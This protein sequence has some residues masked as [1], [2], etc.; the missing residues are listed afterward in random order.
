MA[1]DIS[2]S[3]LKLTLVYQNS[4]LVV[5]LKPNLNQVISWNDN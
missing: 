4:S 2:I 3:H 1:K 5:C